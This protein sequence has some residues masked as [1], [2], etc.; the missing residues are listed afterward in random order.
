MRALISAEIKRIHRKLRS[1]EMPNFS[2]FIFMSF[3]KGVH[4]AEFLP[5]MQLRNSD[6]ELSFFRELKQNK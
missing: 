3:F 2:F 6:G 5:T 4:R 1:A